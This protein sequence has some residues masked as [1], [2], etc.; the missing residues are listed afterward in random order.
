M[1]VVERGFNAFQMESHGLSA[2]R[3][4]KGVREMGSSGTPFHE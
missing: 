3:N 4:A 2:R 1:S